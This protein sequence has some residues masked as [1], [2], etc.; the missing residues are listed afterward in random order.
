MTARPPHSQK[1]PALWYGWVILAVVFIVMAVMVGIRNSLGFFFKAVAGEF[2]WSRAQTAGAYSVGMLLQSICSPLFGS[3]GERWSLRWMMALG[4]LFGGAALLIGS[5]IG[6]LV[7][8]YLMYALLN[9][10]FAASTFVPEVQILSNWFVKRRG[11]AM[12][13]ANSGTG[14]CRRAEPDGSLSHRPDR[15]AGELPCAGRFHDALDLPA[16]GFPAARSP[17]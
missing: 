3:M 9:I 6:G 1:R 16:V 14:I 5:S 8:F 2:G 11:L 13:I 15:M 4:V 10:G 17:P 12:G 7:Q